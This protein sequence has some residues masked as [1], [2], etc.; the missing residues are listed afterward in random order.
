MT[1]AIVPPPTENVSRGLLFSLGS[2]V[3]GVV[4][5][6]IL[7]G[8]IG[9][10]GTVTGVVAVAIPLTSAWLYT[11]GAGAPVKNGRGP[12][13]A[14][15]AVAVVIGAVTSLI[16]GAFAAFTSVGGDGG[17]FAPA[18]WRTVGNLA[19]NPDFLLPIV[20]TLAAGAFGIYLGLR[21]PRTAANPADAANPNRIPPAA[22]PDA[23]TE[24]TPPPTAAP[25]VPSPGV[26]LNGKP[27]DEKKP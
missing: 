10:Y 2:I 5:F 23:P 1:D 4:G 6:L 11:K 26:M 3:V 19:G 16:A 17:F 7:S 9:I 14:I 18:F 25:A 8:V 20:I 15:T 27:L 21:G 24:A 13:I 12:W 22:M